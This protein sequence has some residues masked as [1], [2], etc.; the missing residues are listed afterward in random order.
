MKYTWIFLVLVLVFAY[1]SNFSV[2]NISPWDKDKLNE[3]FVEA[4]IETNQEA[5]DYVQENLELGLIFD[6]INTQN[7]LLMIVSL[8]LTLSFGVA[9]VHNIID[10]LFYKKFYEEPNWQVSI[11][12]GAEVGLLMIALIFLKLIAGLTVFTAIPVVFLFGVV[13][14]YCIQRGRVVGHDDENPSFN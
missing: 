5:Q 3:D 6:Y 7:F 9:V 1:I 4:G 2:R 14:Y 10:K 13:E 8:T 12:R 11:R